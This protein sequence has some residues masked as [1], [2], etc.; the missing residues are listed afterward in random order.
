MD[1]VTMLRSGAESILAR[2][3]EL[4]CAIDGGRYEG[5]ADMRLRRLHRAVLASVI[6][7]NPEP[8]KEYMHR[9]AKDRFERGLTPGEV[10]A[11]FNCLE[12]AMWEQLASSLPAESYEQQLGV[13]NELLQ[14]GKDALAAVYVGRSSEPWARGVAGVPV[15][16]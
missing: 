14:A 16:D 7:Q 4:L 5:V 8:L 10:L 1:L 15:G 2:A 13:L 12:H 3:R 6:D 11:A 9:V